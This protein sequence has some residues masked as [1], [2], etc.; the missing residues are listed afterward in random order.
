MT[1]M[2]NYRLN[3]NLIS[4]L[5]P[6]ESNPMNTENCALLNDSTV[7]RV[8]ALV[9]DTGILDSFRRWHT[10]DNITPRGGLVSERGVLVGLML[11]AREE[12]PLALTSLAEL[13]HSR[14]TS[15]S[16][17]LL[18]LPAPSDSDSANGKAWVNRT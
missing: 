5:N 11:L 4:N 1:G 14:L 8:N 9:T 18:D 2:N 15:A 12:S 6:E 3:D 7:A 13:L 17:E 10:E 16:R